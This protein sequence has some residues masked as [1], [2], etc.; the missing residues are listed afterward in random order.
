M[1]GP[2]LKRQAMVRKSSARGLF[3][4]RFCVTFG[5]CLVG[6]KEAKSLTGTGAIGADHDP[7]LVLLR[8]AQDTTVDSTGT[9]LIRV[10]AA[11]ESRIT[12][13]ELVLIGAAFSFPVVHPDT[14]DVAAS[15]P[16]NLALFK[17]S[18]FG[19]FVRSSDILNHER[20]TDT[21]TVTVR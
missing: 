13:V 11:D 3:C 19:F 12:K 15:F 8:P 14:T 7:P 18:S 1:N 6:C 2:L 21:V 10:T 20:I 16:V 17:H 5:L 4:A 9:L